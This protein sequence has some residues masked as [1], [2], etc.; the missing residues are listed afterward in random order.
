MLTA[1]E[2]RKASVHGTSRNP[3]T[4]R[5]D[6]VNPISKTP[7]TISQSQ[8][9]NILSLDERRAVVTF[10]SHG[11]AAH[12]RQYDRAA[13]IPRVPRGDDR[14]VSDRRACVRTLGSRS[15]G[16]VRRGRSPVPD[17]AR[18]ADGHARSAG[19]QPA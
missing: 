12:D 1:T 17:L 7:P 18:H 13:A 15:D 16:S 3:S 6:V 9:M 14:S 10:P 11:E 4:K 2:A 8:G 5:S 19:Q